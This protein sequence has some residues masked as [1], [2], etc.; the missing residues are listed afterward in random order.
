MKI[1]KHIINDKEVHSND[2]IKENQPKQHKL[3][4]SNYEMKLA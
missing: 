3:Q 1:S 2:Q 4:I